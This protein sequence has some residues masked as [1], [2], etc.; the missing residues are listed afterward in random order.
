MQASSPIELEKQCQASCLVDIGIGGF[1][2]RCHR[3]VT[4]AIVFGVGPRGDHRVSAGES[5]V[6][7]GHWDIGSYE[8][9]A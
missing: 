9:V 4:M 2:S 7:E 6:S 5:G 3:A 8:M 1:L